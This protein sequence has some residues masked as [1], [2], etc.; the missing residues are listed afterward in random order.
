M[1]TLILIALTATLYA[2]EIVDLGVISSR[3]AIILEPCKQ[4]SDFFQFK[5]EL[6]AQ[7]WPS[8][9][10]NIV[11]TN[12][13]L[14]LDKFEA[15]PTGPVIVRVRS[16]CLDGQE[17]PDSRFIL[18]KAPT[19]RDPPTKPKARTVE[20]LTPEEQ[21]ERMLLIQQAT[22]ERERNAPPIPGQTSV[23]MTR[24]NLESVIRELRNHAFG[25]PELPGASSETYSEGIVR[26]RKFYAE[27]RR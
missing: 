11:Q 17:S 16:V 24:Q 8:N 7:R 2:Q 23:P 6:I 15:M 13:M 9:T 10:V 27:P 1:K 19:F 26:M 4:R 25:V 3:K 12:N 18:H 5:I 21:L 14:T 20:I 22:E